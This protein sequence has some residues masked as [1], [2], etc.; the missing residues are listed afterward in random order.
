MTVKVFQQVVFLSPAILEP[1]LESF[2][3]VDWDVADL[4]PSPVH[5]YRLRWTTLKERRAKR[6]YVLSEL[7]FSVLFVS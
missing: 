7:T 1:S 5:V 3:I 2:V 4:E 6:E